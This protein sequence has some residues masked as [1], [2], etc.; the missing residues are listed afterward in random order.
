MFIFSLLLFCFS[1]YIAQN[2]K[3]QEAEDIK[4][5][6]T[7]INTGNIQTTGNSNESIDK[8]LP[9]TNNKEEQTIQNF[10]QAMKEQKFIEMNNLVDNNLKQSAIFRTYFS[11]KRLTRF[12]NN[13]NE[14][15][16]EY[17]DIHIQS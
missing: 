2:K 5:L 8:Q 7:I 15:E 12:I 10:Y 4:S 3:Q 16:V 13:I 14:G 6:T 17:T 1:I 9:F 11:N